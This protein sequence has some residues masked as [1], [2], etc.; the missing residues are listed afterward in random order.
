MPPEAWPDSAEDGSRLQRS[1]LDDEMPARFHK[2]NDEMAQ[3]GR[4]HAASFRH[5]A[6]G[7]AQEA[8]GRAR[9]STKCA[10]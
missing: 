10:E 3:V 6:A 2:L 8:K 1:S 9:G 5:A 4:A 7:G